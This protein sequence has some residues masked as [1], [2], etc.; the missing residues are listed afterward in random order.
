MTILR[1]D[2]VGIVVDDLEAACAFFLEL[3]MEKVGEAPV[4]GRWLDRVLGLED[5]RVDI[6]MLATPDGRSR[7]ELSTYHSPPAIRSE[8]ESPAPNTLGIPRLMFAV[9]DLDEVLARLSAHGVE[10]VGEIE[11]YGDSYRLCY[12]RGPA[13]VIVALAQPL[14]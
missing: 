4:E 10:L 13:G 3:G 6:A 7:L 12:L 9:D 11:Q 2:N 1:M 5:V 14:N 8:P